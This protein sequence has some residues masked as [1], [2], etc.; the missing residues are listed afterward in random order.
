LATLREVVVMLM[1]FGE[2]DF[3]I[4]ALKFFGSAIFLLPF[5][6][7]E[8][9]IYLSSTDGYNVYFTVNICCG[10]EY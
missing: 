10:D 2:N 7:L 6:V 8:T 4:P 3:Y 5:Y 1:F 9:S